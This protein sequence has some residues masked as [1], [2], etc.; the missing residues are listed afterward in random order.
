MNHKTNPNES[1]E[2]LGTLRKSQRPKYPKM[3]KQDGENR[4]LEAAPSKLGSLKLC[5][6]THKYAS[7]HNDLDE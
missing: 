3:G 2:Q 5:I 1:Q 6:W 4:L 7:S